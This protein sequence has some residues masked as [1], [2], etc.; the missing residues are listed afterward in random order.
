MS[1]VIKGT[2][3]ATWKANEPASWNLAF[4]EAGALMMVVAFVVLVL[5]REA[6]AAREV[7]RRAS[8]GQPARPWRDELAEI[9]SGPNARVLITG[10][11]GVLGRA[12]RHRVP[13]HR[14]LREGPARRG[15]RPDHRA[16]G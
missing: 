8:G 15:Q 1:L 9:M 13:G 4:R 2:V 5:V 14:L 12:Q 10:H 6:A 11:P 3:I 16:A 7:G